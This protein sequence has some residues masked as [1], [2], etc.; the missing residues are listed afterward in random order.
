MEAIGKLLAH[1]V[2]QTINDIR[3]HPKELAH[4]S[5]CD[6]YDGLASHF[7]GMHVH[8]NAEDRR[9]LKHAWTQS[10]WFKEANPCSN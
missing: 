1:K 3:Y 7:Y 10:K 5:C 6:L 4:R 9:S 2:I 8:A